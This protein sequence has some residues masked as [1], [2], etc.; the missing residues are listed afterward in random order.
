MEIEKDLRQNLRDRDERTLPENQN[1]ATYDYRQNFKTTEPGKEIASITA[2]GLVT[3]MNNVQIHLCATTARIADT[4]LCFV[5]RR[6][7]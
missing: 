1:R 4:K 3:I 2:M 6:R 7:G 5:Q